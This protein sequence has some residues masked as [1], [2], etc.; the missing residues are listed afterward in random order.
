VLVAIVVISV[1]PMAVEFALH[2]FRKKERPAET[3]TPSE[4]A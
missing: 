1:L 2:S 4:A 3:V